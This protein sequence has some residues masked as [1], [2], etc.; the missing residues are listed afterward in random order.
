MVAHAPDP[1]GDLTIVGDD[2]SRITEGAEVLAR[3]EAEAT[4]GTDTA[5]D[6]ATP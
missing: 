2:R 5:G 6:V 1:V 4:S 3:I